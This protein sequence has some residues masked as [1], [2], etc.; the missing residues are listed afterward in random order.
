MVAGV[1]LGKPEIARDAAEC[2]DT[3]TSDTSD[4]SGTSDTS[5]ING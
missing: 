3:F 1:Y 2:R 5:D 4:T